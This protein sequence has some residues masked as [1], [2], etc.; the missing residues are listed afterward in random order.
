LFDVLLYRQ[1]LFR[2]LNMGSRLRGKDSVEMAFSPIASAFLCLSLLFSVFKKPSLF[3]FYS[4][5]LCKKPSFSLLLF[6]SL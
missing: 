1:T 6:Y 4:F 2:F 3:L 5:T